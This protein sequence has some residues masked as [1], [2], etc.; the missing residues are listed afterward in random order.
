MRICRERAGQR[1]VVRS[2]LLLTDSPGSVVSLRRQ[3]TLHERWPFDTSFDMQQTR[4]VIE[5]NDTTHTPNVEE[6]RMRGKLLP[7]GSVPASRNGDR[8]P[9]LA[10]VFD[11]SLDFRNRAGPK[12]IADPGRIQAGVDIIDKD[13]FRGRKSG[14]CGQNGGGGDP[15]QKIPPPKLQFPSAASWS[16]SLTGSRPVRESDHP[17]GGSS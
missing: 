4:L 13:F 6:R 14:R 2:S 8:T 3:I 5:A 9:V 16:R 17:A 11:Q 1:H 15:L 7:A 10:A 12:D